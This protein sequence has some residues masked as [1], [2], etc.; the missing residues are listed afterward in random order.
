MAAA[1]TFHS[2]A[3]IVLAFVIPAVRGN[4][5]VMRALRL[6]LFIVVGAALMQIFLFSEVD[7]LMDSYIANEYQSQGA[8]IRIGMNLLPSLLILFWQKHFAF[9]PQQLNLWRAMA[10]TSIGC[11]LLL[12]L[13]PNNTTA[14]DRIAL[15]VIPLQIVVGCRL[16]SMR[17]FRL[18]PRQWLVIVLGFCVYRINK[19]L[20]V[21]N[22][23]SLLK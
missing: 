13:F 8:A 18:N 17:I 15:Y 3:L 20:S 1:A 10:F 7:R 21:L 22:K 9:T 2:T 19:Y 12:I 6:L 23:V 14:I 4:S 11:T 5:I 16:P